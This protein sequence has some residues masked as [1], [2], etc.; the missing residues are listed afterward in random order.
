MDVQ[1][2]E[3][4]EAFMESCMGDS[5]HDREHVYR[6]LDTALIID[7]EES[8]VDWE[9]LI[10]ACLLH[11]IGRKEQFEN[12]S[13]CHAQVGAEKACR[14]LTDSGFGVD[15]VEQVR[16]C[17]SSHRFRGDNEPR[18]LEAKIL[19][20]ADKLDVTGAMG[21]ARSLLYQGYVSTPLYR[22]SPEG[23]VL[24]GTGETEPSFFR[25]Y[26]FMLEKLYDR[27]YTRRGREMALSRRQ[28]AVDFYDAL[29]REVRESN[30]EGRAVLKALLQE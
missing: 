20:D 4:V 29:L 16:D 6:V 21:I 14:F 8:D 15:F 18:S 10:C 5:A 25:E 2:Y 26:K 9:V 1:R 30:Q 24:D 13:L 28:A 17:I 11:D 19:F 7:R 27:F 12:P 22:R 3:L 23:E